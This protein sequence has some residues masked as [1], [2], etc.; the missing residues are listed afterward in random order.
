MPETDV[1]LFAKANGFCP[2]IDWLDTLPSKVQ[3]KYIVSIERLEELMT[4][5]KV[6]NAPRVGRPKQ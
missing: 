1:V 5:H 4:L 6:I 2:L 3:D